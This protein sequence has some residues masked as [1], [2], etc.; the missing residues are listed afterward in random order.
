MRAEAGQAA[1][2]PFRRFPDPAGARLAEAGNP[3]IRETQMSRGP[4]TFKQRDV[5]AAIRAAKA[6]GCTVERVEITKDGRIIVVTNKCATEAPEA[7][8]T[9]E[10]DDVV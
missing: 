8:Q 5:A 10:W 1:W 2:Q 6:A 7:H 4:Q 9:N 3:E